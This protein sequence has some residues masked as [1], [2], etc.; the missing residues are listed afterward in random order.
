MSGE[1]SPIGRDNH[2]DNSHQSPTPYSTSLTERVVTAI[3]DAADSSPDD[4][5]PLYAIVDPDALDRL[6][7]PTTQGDTRSDGQVT[8][9]YAGYHVTVTSDGMIELDSLDDERE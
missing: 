5:E 3:T 4:L 2:R 6:F 9:S 1:D 7:A 8:F